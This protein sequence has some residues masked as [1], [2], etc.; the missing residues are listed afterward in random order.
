MTTTFILR[1]YLYLSTKLNIFISPSEAEEKVSSPT[2]RPSDDETKDLRTVILTLSDMGFRGT[3][4][5]FT[6]QIFKSFTITDL[7]PRMGKPYVEE[8]L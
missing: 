4:I 5:S 6:D 7:Y 1:F 3:A 2:F 8:L